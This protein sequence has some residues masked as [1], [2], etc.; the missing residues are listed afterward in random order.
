MRRPQRASGLRLAADIG[1]TFTDVAVFDDRSGTLRFGKVLST[2]HHAN[3]SASDALYG[4][5][6]IR[7]AARAAVQARTDAREAD[8]A[9]V[10]DEL[11]STGIE[12]LGGLA[13]ALT[14]RSIP[15]ARGGSA[16]SAVQVSRVMNRLNR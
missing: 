2:P 7:K 14:D 10:I 1:G 12:S 15:T 5:R 4:V 8:L 11:R 9:P 16:W 3:R 6:R 13:R